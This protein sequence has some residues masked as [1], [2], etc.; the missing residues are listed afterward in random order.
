MNPPRS[1][2]VRI[3]QFPKVKELVTEAKRVGYPVEEKKMDRTPFSFI[4]RDPENNNATVF[5]AVQVRPGVWAVSY[6]LAY[7]EE[8]EPV[9]PATP[10][11]LAKHINNHPGIA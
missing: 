9:L 8:P 3:A 11:N 2:F 6:P 7:W 10:L 5:R 1:T 4:A